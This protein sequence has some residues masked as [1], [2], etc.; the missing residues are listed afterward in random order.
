MSELSGTLEGVGL[1]AIVRFLAG[2]KKTGCLRISH[3]DL[4]GEIF[5]DVGQVCGA[6]IGSRRGLSALDALVQALPGGSFTFE[7]DVRPTDGASIDLS[8]EALQGHLDELASRAA[9]G[10]PQLPSVEAVPQLL[11]TE[12]QSEEPL[13]LDRGTLQTLLAVDGQRTVR[14]IIAQRGTWDALWQLAS[15]GEVGLISLTTTRS[16]A[17][18]SPVSPVLRPAAADATA[19]SR[20]AT[21]EVKTNEPASH[22]PKLGFEDDPANSF[23]RPTRLHRCFAPGTPLPLSLDQQR[24]LCLTEQFGTC[25]RLG[26]TAAGP[27]GARRTPPVIPPAPAVG[28]AE[29]AAQSAADS[30]PGSGHPRIV[31]LPFIARAAAGERSA[32]ADR[33]AVGGPEPTRF[34]NAAAPAQ[35]TVTPPPTPL[36]ARIARSEGPADGA[37]A[38]VAAGAPAAAAAPAAPAAAAAPGAGARAGAAGGRPGAAG[39]AAADAAGAA[40]PRPAGSPLS[41]AVAPRP[42]ADK[43]ADPTTTA[44]LY[45]PLVGGADRRIFGVPVAVLPGAV[46]ILAVLGAVAYLLLPQMGDLLSEDPLNS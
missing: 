13:P 45:K 5:F 32:V 23:G 29:R 1:P 44:Q 26:L 34:R 14:D 24:E 16:D 31:R 38:T 42:P 18:P 25:P 40:G 2:L 8:Q 33:Q 39:A 20:P 10:T 28:R 30:A 19:F 12:E 11:H 22:C 9:N 17:T 15:L 27:D 37:A 35:D 21:L 4:R 7:S 36:R 46:V 6:S 3:A 41:A 43:D